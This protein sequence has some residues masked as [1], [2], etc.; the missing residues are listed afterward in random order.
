MRANPALSAPS[1]LVL[2]GSPSALAPR[3]HRSLRAA[4]AA[5][6]AALADALLRELERLFCAPGAGSAPL[7][8][9]REL[10]EAARLRQVG[11]RSSSCASWLGL[12]PSN[13]GGP[14]ES[15]RGAGAPGVHGGER[16]IA[17]R[18]P[19]SIRSACAPVA[20]ECCSSAGC[21]RGCFRRAPPAAADCRR[22]AARARGGIGSGPAATSGFARGRALPAL[23]LASR[24]QQ[25]L[26][27]S[28]HTAGDD[29]APRPRSLFVDDVCDLFEPIPVRSAAALASTAVSWEAPVRSAHSAAA[30]RAR[31]GRATPAAAVVGLFART[32]GGCPVKWFVERLLRGEE[33][34]PDAEPLARGSLTH[35][36]LKLTLER[37]RERTGSARITPTR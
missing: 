18:W 29:G 12:G 8:A 16:P 21:R 2:C 4:A 27:L 3:S 10:D 34:G 22:A 5:G 20:W 6:R 19:S 25:R 23:R 14:A 30:R 32:V 11:V 1:E 28:W 31:L 33:L 9:G 17:G 7:L 26:I 35:A 13:A 36:A 24:P 15:S 37:L